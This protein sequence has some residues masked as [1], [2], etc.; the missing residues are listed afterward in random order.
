MFRLNLK[1]RMENDTG[2]RQIHKNRGIYTLRMVK[3]L[4]TLILAIVISAC[5]SAHAPRDVSGGRSA[6]ASEQLQSDLEELVEGFR[7]DVGVYVRHLET[8][9]T[10][11]LQADSL[12]P[13]ASMVK[14]PI[15][16]KT[17]DAIES[18]R[19]SYRD[20]LVY[21]D[22]LLYPGVDLLGSFRDGE[23]IELS[24]VI[25]L[26]TAMSDNTASLWLQH[27][28]G[29]GE[30]INDWLESEGFSST[31]VNSRTPGRESDWEVYGWGQTTPRE[32]AELMTRIRTGRAVSPA[33]D[34]TMYRMLS[35]SY[36]DDRALSQIPPWVQTAA[37]NGAVNEARSE[38][39]FVNAPHGGYVFSVL[40]NNQQ[41]ESW[42][43]ENEGFTLIRDVSRLLWNHFE[44]DSEWEPAA[45]P[46]GRYR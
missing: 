18:G 45:D 1:S 29:G 25:L 33:A 7:G 8:G 37:K 24:K 40:T 12:F 34:E 22:S 27:L 35:K 21:R 17:F 36:W 4:P 20:E 41:D 28:C 39:V 46:E 14:V 10:A 19:L 32:I 5:S 2:M 31:R 42:N 30:A 23:K 16:I 38:V 3:R 9:E 26:M 44:P 43:W 13:T 11:A 6:E 15:L